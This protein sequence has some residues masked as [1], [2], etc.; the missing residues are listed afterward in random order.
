M[1]QD[2]IGWN[3]DQLE[4]GIL[5]EKAPLNDTKFVY[6]SYRINSTLRINLDEHYGSVDLCCS[7]HLK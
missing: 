4:Y 6:Y 7:N 5:I 2:R 1:Y 3:Y